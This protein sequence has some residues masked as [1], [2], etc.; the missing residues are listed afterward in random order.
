MD[1]VRCS[2]NID[3]LLSTVFDGG[4]VGLRSRNF[5]RDVI[6]ASTVLHQP[7]QLLQ[8]L[9]TTQLQAHNQS[10]HKRSSIER[11]ASI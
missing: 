8:T 3:V 7:T 6:N 2:K 5:T 1:S 11:E 4:T 9:L 10:G